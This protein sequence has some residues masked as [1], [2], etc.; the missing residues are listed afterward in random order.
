[1][2]EV[3]RQGAGNEHAVTQAMTEVFRQR[4]ENKDVGVKAVI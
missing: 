4:A 3:L 1:M 2:T